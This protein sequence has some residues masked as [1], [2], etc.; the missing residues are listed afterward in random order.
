[1]GADLI[2]TAHCWIAL[3]PVRAQTDESAAEFVL[4]EFDRETA[5]E[6]K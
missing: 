2:T 1:M 5:M 4:E 6:W 3:G